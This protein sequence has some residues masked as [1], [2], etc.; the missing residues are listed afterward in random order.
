MKLTSLVVFLYFVVFN[1]SLEVNETNFEGILKT[2][3]KE[4]N[5]EI[6]S[7]ED[8]EENISKLLGGISLEDQ[9]ANINNYADKIFEKV[10]RILRD[11][12]FDSQ[13]LPDVSFKIVKSKVQLSQGMLQDLTTMERGGDV[14]LSF[15]ESLDV[16]TLSLPIEFEELEFSYHFHTKIIFSISGGVK[17]SVKNIRL[18]AKLSYD[19]KAHS[20]KLKECNVNSIGKI[21]VKFTG[22]K[23]VVWLINGITKVIVPF[24]K[25]KVT[26]I[27]EDME[28]SILGEVVSKLNEIMHNIFH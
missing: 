12:N 24:V 21:S 26:R 4:H 17:G 19:V 28:Q 23:A 20:F 15:V 8:V 11:H 14:D 5:S 25:G 18:Y 27:V 9:T 16:I 7:K 1:E 2:T 6:I 3:L 13:S 22:H 10:R